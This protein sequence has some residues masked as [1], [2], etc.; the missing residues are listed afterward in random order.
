MKITHVVVAL[1]LV[2]SLPSEAAHHLR[3]S[4]SGNR[5]HVEAQPAF[6]SR[7]QG[8]RINGREITAP[9]WSFACM[10]DQGPR[11]CWRTHVGLWES[12]LSRAI[13]QRVLTLSAWQTTTK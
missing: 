7:L 5:V 10:S 3:T 13:R 12:R 1:L 4:N 2:P 9:P 11:Q 8:S 6:G